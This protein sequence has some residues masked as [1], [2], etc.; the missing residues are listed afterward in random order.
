MSRRVRLHARIGEALEALYGPDAEAHAA[1][2][3]YHFAQAEPVLGTDKLVKYCLLAGEQALAAHAWEEALQHFQRGLAAKG[4][5]PEGT[6]P[7]RDDEEAALLCGLGR[8]RASTADRQRRQEAV[9][10]LSRAFDYYETTGAVAKAVAIAEYPLPLPPVGRTG[11]AMFIPRALKLVPPDTRAAGRLLSSYGAELGRVEN[12]YEGAQE[13]FRRALAIARR[14]QDLPL[15]IRSLAASAN[16]DL[17]HIHTREAL[18]KAGQAIEFARGLD[19]PQAMWQT[20]LVAV[21]AHWDM[22]DSG[23]ARQHVLALQD[24]SVRLRDRHR[25]AQAFAYAARLDRQLGNWRRA[26]ESSDQGLAIAPQ[27]HTLL[28]DRVMLEYEVGD[29][30]DGEVYL[31]RLLESIPPVA[32]RSG[33]IYSLPAQVIPW[34]ART[35]GGMD[36][37]DVAAEVARAALSSPFSNP[38][39]VLWPRAGLALL[40]VVRGDVA[41]AAE[42]YEILE[43]HRGSMAET[44]CFDHLLGLLSHTVGNLDRATVHFE[45]ALA[46]CRKA[47]YRPELAWSLFDYADMLLSRNSPGDQQKANTLLDESLAIT[48]ELG[49]RPLLERVVLRQQKAKSQSTRAP[50]YP[51]GLS[52]REVEVLRLVGAG[53]SNPEVAEGLFISINTVTR[54]LTNIFTKTGTVNRAE[55]AVYAARHG[56]L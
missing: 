3:A 7:A 50:A 28:G 25:L 6:V 27:D 49:M 31:E 43:P 11:S 21:R 24:L 1:E 56:L 44:S 17:S 37:L 23:A 51:D 16:V 15:E 41:A 45:D 8:A 38:I 39:Y 53:K 33:T 47:G 40:A 2:L 22:G 26:R 52:Q 14:E 10:I 9:D 20:H 54:H 5:S 12:D 29:F 36:R 48:K 18:E 35:S 13:A 34:V 32:D 19:D 42:Q 46:F 30:D 55:A 4:V